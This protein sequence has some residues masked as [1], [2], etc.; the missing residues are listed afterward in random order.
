M[1]LIR[2]HK[3][4]YKKTP[5]KRTA[6]CQ[7]YEGCAN[8]SWSK[9]L[10]K[11]LSIYCLIYAWQRQQQRA[12]SLPH[13]LDCRRFIWRPAQLAN[14]A[15]APAFMLCIPTRSL[16]AL[17][18]RALLDRSGGV[19]NRFFIFAKPTLRHRNYGP[20]REAN[21]FIGRLIN[22]TVVGFKR[23]TVLSDG[24]SGCFRV[25]K[26]VLFYCLQKSRKSLLQSREMIKSSF[27]SW[28]SYSLL[29]IVLYW[30]NIA[31]ILAFNMLLTCSQDIL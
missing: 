25:F 7:R 10:D 22:S 23:L 20:T 17:T 29:G 1:R 13:E 31:Y 26:C 6:S 16:V 30:W 15:W 4:K 11:Y 5:T 9:S 24:M 18:C 19:E 21:W 27:M 8:H 28:D 2:I 14:L 12:P 3:W